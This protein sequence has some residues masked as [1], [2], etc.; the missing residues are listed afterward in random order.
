MIRAF[1][2]ALLC[3]WVLT[4]AAGCRQHGAPIALPQSLDST[5]DQPLAGQVSAIN[6]NGAVSFRVVA[7][8][9]S[10]RIDLDPSTGAFRYVPNA[11]FFGADSFSYVAENPWRS[12]APAVVALHVQNVDDVPTL[13]AIPDLQNSA[14]E[15]DTRYVVGADDVDG[16][17]LKYS[18]WVQDTTIARAAID[19]ATRE[20]TIEPLARGATQVSV[21]V[22]DGHST[23][24]TE[25]N[26]SVGDVMKTVAIDTAAE[27]DRAVTLHNEADREV[28]FDFKHNG[29]P[30]LGSDEQMVEY[31]RAMAP[32]FP[33][34]PFE[35]KLWRFIRNSTYHWAPLSADQWIGDPWLVVSSLGWGFCGEVAAT[36]VRLARAAGYEA[37]VYGLTGHVVP[38]IKIGERWQMFDPDMALYYRTRSGEIAGV[39]DLVADPTLITQPTAPVLDT[40]ANPLPYSEL[41]ASFYASTANNYIADWVFLTP[42]P[43][44][45]PPLTLPPGARFV[46]PGAWTERPIGYDGETPY[47][48]PAFVQGSLTIPSGWTGA[49]PLPWRL[50]AVQGEGRVR[51]AGQEL[52]VGSP[53]LAEAL[54]TNPLEYDRV[55]ILEAHSPLRI[56]MFMNSLRYHL[57][58]SNDLELRGQDVWAI[59]IASATLALQ[60]VSTSGAGYAKPRPIRP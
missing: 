29:F 12:S 23:V 42:Q 45:R 18:S 13:D 46:Y 27:S 8:P 51:L 24:R 5:E 47:D 48:V 59:Q 41:I 15:R 50:A 53:E 34:E 49:L 35:R 33:N 30:T 6:L 43:T 4:I 36:Y 25:F 16:D 1:A 44:P 9:H 57:Q 54:R 11:D 26:F 28:A 21:E 10:G 32:V 14:Y 56:V 3:A 19:P 55:E 58:P 2:T 60:H 17:A 7:A 20:L 38:E 37:R 39:D 40:E 52:E 22:S 31:V